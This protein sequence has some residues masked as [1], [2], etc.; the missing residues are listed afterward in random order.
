MTKASAT[1]P[2]NILCMWLWTSE[3]CSL[4]HEHQVSIHNPMHFKCCL[5]QSL[6]ARQYF[7]FSHININRT[8]ALNPSCPCPCSLVH[9]HSH[10]PVHRS[11][12]S[13][14]SAEK[15]NRDAH[16]LLCCRLLSAHQS[17][18]PWPSHP[19][20][21]P[22]FSFSSPLLFFPD[23]FNHVVLPPSPLPL[24]VSQN[25]LPSI[26]L[27]FLLLLTLLWILFPV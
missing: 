17:V 5:Q 10:F 6:K 2:L 22:H 20:S 8:V 23:V 3:Q 27:S 4:W 11:R 15:S 7:M 13:T 25:I 18:R 26:I 24:P 1:V 14:V 19:Y 12:I 9:D 16:T 21:P